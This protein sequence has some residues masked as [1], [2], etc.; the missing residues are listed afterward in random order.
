MRP[1]PMT[2]QSGRLAIWRLGGILTAVTLA[3]SGAVQMGGGPVAAMVTG[4]A[5]TL[6]VAC[7]AVGAPPG[8]LIFL[9][10]GALQIAWA[11]IAHGGDGIAMI[12]AAI[13]RGSFIIGLFS[14]L[15][16]I[17]AAA[18][19][20]HEIL[21]CGRFL[22]RQPPGR[23]YLALTIG[24]HL[25]GLILMYGSISLLGG[26]AAESTSRLSDPQ[27]RHHRL[28]RML[29]A[30]QRGFAAT[31]CW[32]PL[33][34]G[35]VLATT[36][37]PGASWRDALP[38]AL[39]SAALVMGVGWA[40]DS[41]F[42][43]RISALPPATAPEPGRWLPHLRPLLLLLAL[44]FAGIE[45]VHALTGVGVIGSVMVVVPITAIVWIYLQT[46]RLTVAEAAPAAAGA[47]PQ[48][49]GSTALAATARRLGGFV[50]H[51]LVGYR[52]EVLILFMAA[53]I[54]YLGAELLVPLLAE[55]GIGLGMLPGWA[56]IVGLI[57]LIPAAGQ[58]GMNPI[59]VVSLT[60]PLLP[61]PASVG[62]TPEAMVVAVTG[63]WAISG[64]TSPFTASVMLVGALSGQSA[65][66]AGLRWNG[67][68]ALILGVILSAW[69]LLV[70]AIA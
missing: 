58:I 49:V 39:V 26:L 55:A 25:F 66:A 48:A 17:R 34:F 52:A 60:L 70:A 62:L 24:G 7:F 32:S 41:I 12:A 53:F 69:A 50:T 21:E 51:D 57:W 19:G 11:L 20:S 9:A 10:I 29:I 3:G 28:R 54:G 36:L 67:A 16:V 14:A 23:R 59:L 63:G 65:R 6:A 35:M 61:A 46:R 2:P 30:I 68:I 4:A 56:V 38:Y 13:G 42:K 1:E 31:L 18:M 43:P 40:L 15:L 8:R 44:V 47:A 37:I 5:V 22:A 33:A 45:A 27:L 64:I